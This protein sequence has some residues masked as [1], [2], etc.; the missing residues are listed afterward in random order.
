MNKN[1]C[2]MLVSNDTYSLPIFCSDTLYHLSLILD[3]PYG[4]VKSAF[5]KNS[6]IRKY[7]GIIEKVIL[8]IDN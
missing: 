5:K 6:V 2:F 8:D 7:N 4:T 1:I 3:I